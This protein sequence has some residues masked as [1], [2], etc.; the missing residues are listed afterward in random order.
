VI[1]LAQKPSDFIFVYT[2]YNPHEK[3]QIGFFH[4]K[5]CSDVEYVR[6]ILED[7]PTPLPYLTRKPALSSA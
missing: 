4:L 7:S 5:I 3:K 2:F 6:P 1:N